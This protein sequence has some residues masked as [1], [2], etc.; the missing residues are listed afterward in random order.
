MKSNAPAVILRWGIAFVFFYAAIDSLISPDTWAMYVPAFVTA[1]VSEKI[2]LTVFSLYQLV[3]AGMLFMGKKL[4][5]VTLL[6]TITLGAIVVVDFFVIDI[7][8]RDVGLA[9]AAL[10]LFEMVKENENNKS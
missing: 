8:F 3:L 7:V 5:W 9:F 10:A 4:Y 2:F 1:I 6:A